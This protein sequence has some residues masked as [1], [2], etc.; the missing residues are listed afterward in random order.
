MKIRKYIPL[1]LIYFIKTFTIKD[2]IVSI[3]DSIRLASKPFIFMVSL[4]HFLFIKE[5]LT[6]IKK[7]CFHPTPKGVGFSHLACKLCYGK[8]K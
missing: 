2:T 7:K 6:Y 4:Y 5:T 1:K 8:R 3:N